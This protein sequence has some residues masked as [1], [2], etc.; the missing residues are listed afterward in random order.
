MPTA[1]TKTGFANGLGL[2]SDGTLLAARYHTRSVA[3]AGDKAQ[4]QTQTTLYTGS[5]PTAGVG[6]SESLGSCR[7]SPGFTLPPRGHHLNSVGGG[8][9]IRFT[10]APPPSAFP[11]AGSGSGSS[12]TTSSRSS[13]N[14]SSSSSSSSG[15]GGGGSS[16]SSSSSAAEL[17][18]ATN[19]SVSVLFAVRNELSFT[20]QGAGKTTHLF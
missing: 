14:S 16:S 8:L 3:V 7:W 12:S 6:A 5:L 19:A 10:E 20:P 17:V 15:G 18:V 13:S 11:A 9:G 1:P 4:T 2:L